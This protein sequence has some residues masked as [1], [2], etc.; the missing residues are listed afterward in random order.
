MLGT[1]INYMIATLSQRSEH[2]LICSSGVI[3]VHRHSSN[4][5]I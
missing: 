1:N 3:N 5:T 4:F 2:I